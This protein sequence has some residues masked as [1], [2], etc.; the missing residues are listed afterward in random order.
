MKRYWTSGA[1]GV[2]MAERAA[3]AANVHAR[4]ASGDGQGTGCYGLPAGA[5]PPDT[6][7]DA[8][9]SWN[10]PP[11]LLGQRA[12]QTP[13]AVV[14]SALLFVGKLNLV[15]VALVDAREVHVRGVRERAT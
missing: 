5:G 14:S 12:S 7:G 11:A 1:P 2:E 4:D 6:L 15:E 13:R 9:E 10:P 8:P 3:S